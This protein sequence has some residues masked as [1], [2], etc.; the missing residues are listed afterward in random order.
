MNSFWSKK[1][2]K[3]VTDVRKGKQWK[4]DFLVKSS[5]ILVTIRNVLHYLILFSP[6]KTSFLYLFLQLSEL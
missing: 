6:I 5:N 4:G 1:Y 2:E 3:A